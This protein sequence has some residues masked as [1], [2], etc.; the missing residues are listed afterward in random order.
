MRMDEWRN[1]LAQAEWDLKAARDSAVAGNFEWAC[2]QCQQ[3]AAKAL[4]AYL[5]R[6]GGEPLGLHSVRKLLA[7]WEEAAPE[8]GALRPAALLDR[9]YIPTRYPNGL[10]G[11]VPHEYFTAEAA[12]ECLSQ[13]S[14]VIEFV[15]R[16]SAT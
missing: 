12:Q 14:S 2:F 10:P 3:A 7:A 16:S 8:F 6:A 1:W 13:A 9:Y 4:K 11:D 5:Y 15:V